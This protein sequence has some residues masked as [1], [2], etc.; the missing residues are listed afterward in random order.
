[1][2]VLSPLEAR[3]QKLPKRPVG[4]R[5]DEQPIERHQRNLREERAVT[6]APH[7]Q[8]AKL[9][10][11]E[12][13]DREIEPGNQPEWPT[14]QAFGARQQSAARKLQ[15]SRHIEPGMRPICGYVTHNYYVPK[16]LG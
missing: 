3:G 9:H 16:P 6:A 5:R 4:R 15:A 13:A 12:I 8:E 11:R 10:R 1:M 7:G 2:L 14:E